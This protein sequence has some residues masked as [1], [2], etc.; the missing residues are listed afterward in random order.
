VGHPTSTSTNPTPVITSP[1]PW[2]KV[3]RAESSSS[4]GGDS[5]GRTAFWKRNMDVVPRP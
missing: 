2:A 4:P 1:T 3:G 5:R